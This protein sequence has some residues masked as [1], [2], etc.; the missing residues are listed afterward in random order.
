MENPHI[1]T[2]TL[3]QERPRVTPANALSNPQ[4]DGNRLSRPNA[5]SILTSTRPDT[6]LIQSYNVIDSDTNALVASPISYQEQPSITGVTQDSFQFHYNPLILAGSGA[7]LS[8]LSSSSPPSLSASLGIGTRSGASQ[9]GSSVNREEGLSHT[10]SLAVNSAAQQT[11]LQQQRYQQQQHEQFSGLRNCYS[12]SPVTIDDALAGVAATPISPVVGAETISS[13]NAS[14]GPGGP[15]SALSQILTP[16]PAQHPRIAIPTQHQ[17][18]ERQERPVP[19]IN[20]YG[21]TQQQHE[22]RDDHPQEPLEPPPSYSSIVQVVYPN[23]ESSAAQIKTRT[24]TTVQF[25]DNQPPPLSSQRQQTNGRTSSG[26]SVDSPLSRSG[27]VSSNAA[28]NANFLTHYVPKKPL[29]ILA[30]NPEPDNTHVGDG[31]GPAV[32]IAIGKTGHGKSSLLNRILGTKELKASASVR[33][34]TK[35][36]AERTGWARFEDNRRFLVTVADTPGLAD[37][38]GNDEV[39]IPILKEYINSVGSRVGITAFLLVFKIDSSVDAIMTILKS[40]NE[41][42]RDF[43]NVWDNVILVFTGCDFRR[44]ILATKQLLHKELKNQIKERILD[45]LRPR[46]S[47][48]NENSS[49]STPSSS[50]SRSNS[51]STSSFP[52]PN[53]FPSRSATISDGVDND[54]GVPMVFLTTAENVCSFA[55]GAGRCDCDDHSYYLR[56]CL[57]RLWYEARKMKRWVIESGDDDFSG[58]V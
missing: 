41:I 32:L 36:I 58:H 33:A 5:T 23:Q 49:T 20:S 37:T 45:H 51:T 4:Q 34:V 48:V 43:P 27:T 17:M 44:D 1:G 47:P 7:T 53:R 52:R 11:L 22:Q 28:F 29:N 31:P 54:A 9:Q 42:T 8:P 46:S 10:R 3:Q 21:E 19:N 15:T 38:E 2:N 24:K 12:N 57:K 14:A 35:G 16:I 25:D 50:S 39:N 18:A 30:Q 26:T 13:T 56:S 40:F 55:L 6:S